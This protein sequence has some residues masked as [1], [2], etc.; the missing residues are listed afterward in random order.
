MLFLRLLI[1]FSS[2]L[3]RSSD[4]LFFSCSSS[5]L[6]C[7]CFKFQSRLSAALEADLSFIGTG[8]MPRLLLL[9]LAL[10]GLNGSL[11]FEPAVQREGLA[12]NW[13]DI[14]FSAFSFWVLISFSSSWAFSCSRWDLRLKG[15]GS[16]GA[17]T[18]APLEDGRRRSKG[19]GTSL[20]LKEFC[21]FFASIASPSMI[22]SSSLFFFIPLVSVCRLK[23][24]NEV[25][26]LL[27]Q[28]SF[29][30]CPG[31][32][33]FL[34]CRPLTKVAPRAAV[35]PPFPFPAG[36]GPAP[37]KSLALDLVRK[38]GELMAA[39]ETIFLPAATVFLTPTLL[40]FMACEVSEEVDAAPAP[41]D[42]CLSSSLL[43]ALVFVDSIGLWGTVKLVPVLGFVPVLRA[44][45]FR[46]LLLRHMVVVG[47]L[48]AVATAG[49]GG[50]TEA[51]VLGSVSNPVG[52]S[53]EALAP[54]LPETFSS[55]P[56][57]PV[58]A[59]TAF[60]PPAA[61]ASGAP[62]A[63]VSW[64]IWHF[65]G[66]DDEYVQVR[67]RGVLRSVLMKPALSRENHSSA[68]LSSRL[69]R[70]S[71]SRPPAG[72]ASAV[73]SWYLGAQNSYLGS[74]LPP[75]GGVHSIPSSDIGKTLCYSTTDPP[76]LRQ[77]CAFCRSSCRPQRA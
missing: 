32:D 9:L 15:L 49:P 18:A 4:L 24:S 38:A 30:L 47:M 5:A 64:D 2:A 52:F 44:R 37:L 31:L 7:F 21:S 69:D 58:T 1:S 74:T 3:W 19:F 13:V 75:L 65:D 67:D 20:A 53:S 55:T 23:G 62:A 60:A 11:F 63:S 57:D 72:V 8:M 17:F 77:A 39:R 36:P 73:K 45:L 48:G 33:I 50:A 76:P 68:S 27:L 61:C 66:D 42:F 6:L 70:S 41:L 14:L 29:F 12:L 46:R 26:R 34:L 56:L 40:G 35:F 16:V 10:R 22:L 59:I 43:L 25:V 28:T 51:T 71:W 54:S